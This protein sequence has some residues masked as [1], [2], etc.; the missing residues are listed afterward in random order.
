MMK[1]H[2]IIPL[3]QNNHTHVMNYF[4]SLAKVNFFMIK[5]E[6]NTDNKSTHIE[7]HRLSSRTSQTNTDKMT[8]MLSL[9]ARFNI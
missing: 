3:Y 7:R 2:A 9:R 5:S 1:T 8:V 6:Q 4:S